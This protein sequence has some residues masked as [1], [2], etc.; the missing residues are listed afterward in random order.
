MFDYYKGKIVSEHM[1]SEQFLIKTINFDEEI[2]RW[3]PKNKIK[4]K[5]NAKELVEVKFIEDSKKYNL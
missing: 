2:E 5:L 4:R 3:V 1:R